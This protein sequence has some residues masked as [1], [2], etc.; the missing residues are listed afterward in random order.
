ML[1]Q[2]N[3]QATDSVPARI[4][5]THTI[6]LYHAMNEYLLKQPLRYWWLT[7]LLIAINCGLLG[8]QVLSGV[9]A[10]DPSVADLIGWGADFAPLTLTNE[11]WRLL[12]SMFLHIGVVHLLLNMWGLYLLGVYAEFYYGRFWYVIIYLLAGLAG[13]LASNYVSLHNALSF[14]NT[15]IL[16]ASSSLNN[17]L[18][19]SLIPSVSA[20]ASGAIMGVCGALLV[21]ALWP[22]RDIEA[23]YLLNKNALLILTLLNLGIGIFVGGINS[24]AHLGGFVGGLILALGYLL[25]QHFPSVGKYTLQLGWIACSAA[26]LMYV[27]FWLMQHAKSLMHFWSIYLMQFKQ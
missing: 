3:R 20:G 23:K 8:W 13:N 19:N 26:V 16:Q 18:T 21:A 22:K 5:L 11:N 4:L 27:D 10:T 25:S 6:E 17:S 15:A 9:S 1:L 24:M 12:S 14:S 7:A 2:A